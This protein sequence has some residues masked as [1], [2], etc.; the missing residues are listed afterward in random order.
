ML[1]TNKDLTCIVLKFILYI[2]FLS[3]FS[4]KA[5]LCSLLN[6]ENI[7][8]YGPQWMASFNPLPD[9]KILASSKT[10]ADNSQYC[11]NGAICL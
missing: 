7:E 9:N 8:S 4:I 2:F 10:L 11:S 1:F 6:E 3:T 5:Q